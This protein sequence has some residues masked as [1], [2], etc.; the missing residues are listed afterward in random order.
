M[1]ASQKRS[2]FMETLLDK[3]SELNYCSP[4]GI[5]NDACCDYETVEKTNDIISSRISELVAT[6]FFKYYKLNLY[7][8]CPF[9]TE[10]G[11]CNN[12]ACAVETIDETHLPESWRSIV[13]GAIQTS[14]A[15][16]QFQPYKKCEYRDQDFCVVEDEA[17]IEG[18]YVNLLDNPERFTG[19][20]GES[21][22]RVWE[23]IYGENCF[24]LV[25]DTDL[26]KISLNPAINRQQLGSPSKVKAK[27]VD[28]DV[29]FEK[30]VYYRLISGLHSSIS[31]H[32]CDEYLNQTTGQWG[33]NLDCFIS[34]FSN[35]PERIENAYFT[36]VVL[37]RAISKMS[38][39]LKVYEFCTGDKEQDVQVKRMVSELVNTA[40]SCPGTFDEKQMFASPKS[41]LLKEEF[42]L[43]FRN[44]SRI[45]DCV[46]CDKCRLWGKLQISGLGTA[47]KVLFSYDDEYFNPKVHP[48]LLTRTEIVALFNAFNRLS[49]SLK[50]IERFRMMYQQRINDLN[51]GESPVPVNTNNETPPI[52][53][54]GTQ[55]ITN[56]HFPEIDFFINL[57]TSIKE[58]ISSYVIKFYQLF[59]QLL[60][61]WHI[62]VPVAL[63]LI[64]K[65]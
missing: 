16:P 32:I 24:N 1:A 43:H 37:L 13:L 30:R 58:I 60:E 41:R 56:I 54:I 7:K 46:G 52:V 10:Y 11:Q 62:P 63:K 26:S 4:S 19:Y 14:S 57:L 53:V 39:Y 5:I 49:E 31:I 15:G 22:S 9:W 48:N 61:H 64:I 21:A 23:A 3:S 38:E 8:E 6:D 47:L 42:K 34:R 59:V 17:D 28:S 65:D 44:V 50:A 55:N 36:Y 25:H 35:H 12:R 29:C 45:M 40:D 2:E 27:K 20:A 51:D 18:V 33:P